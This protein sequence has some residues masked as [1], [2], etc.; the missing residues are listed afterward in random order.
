MPWRLLPKRTWRD[1]LQIDMLLSAVSVLVVA[2]PSS[3][4]PKGLMNYPVVYSFKLNVNF[5][6]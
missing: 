2:L 3:E 5:F 4:I 1:Y 6:L